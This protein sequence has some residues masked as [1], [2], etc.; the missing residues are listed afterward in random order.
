[1]NS[2]NENKKSINIFSQKKKKKKEIQFMILL[3]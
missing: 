3:F 1:M 2:F